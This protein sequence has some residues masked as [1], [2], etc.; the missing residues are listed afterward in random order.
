M[1]KIPDGRTLNTKQQAFVEEYIVDLNG[2]QAAIRAGYAKRSSTVTAAQLLAKP[3]IKAAV[4]K[5]MAERSERTKIDAEWVLKASKDLYD[6]CMQIQPVLDKD[7]R[8]TGDFRFEHTGAGKA[9][10]LIG[11]HV[12]VQAFREQMQQDITSGGKPIVNV[13]VHQAKDSGESRD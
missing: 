6:K 8:P 13:M 3:N 1:P 11:K 2:S 7:G 4:D 10:D 9:L 12:G 5:L